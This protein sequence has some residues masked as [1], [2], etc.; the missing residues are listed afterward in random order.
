MLTSAR[1]FE[2]HLDWLGRRFEFVSLDEIGFTLEDGR[3]FRKPA[4]AI[5]FDDGYRDVYYNACPILE[6]KGI[7]AGIFLVS[8]LVGTRRL[9][10]YDKLYL[11]L[12]RLT[13]RQSLLRASISDTVRSAGLDCPELLNLNGAAG[14]PFLLMRMI[15]SRFPQSAIAELIAL[16]EPAVHLDEG[17]LEELAPMTWEM[18][19]DMRRK[20]FAIGSHTVSHPLLTQESASTVEFE[21]VCS[22]QTIE[23]RLGAAIKHFA[24]PDGRFN[25]NVVR[26]VQA[27][28]YR[29]AYG[30]CPARDPGHPLLTIPRKVLWEKAAIDPR[31]RFSHA[32]MNCHAHWAFDRLHGCEHDHG[33]NGVDQTCP[34]RLNIA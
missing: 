24:Y 1:M 20:G 16:L 32:M 19:S 25:D 23:A 17:V 7:P 8:D 34:V 3:R 4:A 28:G 9:P 11:L 15:L 27:A 12:A 18:V 14:Q 5:T 31:G 26:A 29:Y 2:Q 30:I 10:V 33:L 6:R 21:V 22:K 13:H